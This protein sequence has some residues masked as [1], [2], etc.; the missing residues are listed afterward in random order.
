M[1]IKEEY[2]EEIVIQ[3]S[4]FIACLKTCR[5]EE[6][7][8]SYIEQIRKEFSDASHVCTAFSIGENREIQRSSDNGEPAGTAGVPMLE[9]IKK[10]D[11]N[12]VC[13]CVVRYF[14]GIKLGAGGL[15]RAYSGS[16]SDALKHAPKVKDVP[17]FI[18]NITYDYSLVGNIESY[19]RRNGTILDIEYSDKVS[20]AFS[21]ISTI[22]VMQD[23]QNISKGQATVTCVEKTFAEVDA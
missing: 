20:V 7:A 2:R 22:E 3:K 4:R 16:V 21:A 18:Y 11:I 1:R 12:D 19:L 8:R 6:E 10:S 9:S 5:S 15:I 23:I 17:V 14:G 13:A